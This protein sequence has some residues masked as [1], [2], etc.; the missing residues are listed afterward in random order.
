M[1]SMLQ[2]FKIRRYFSRF[3]PHTH[4]EHELRYV[5]VQGFPSAL[6]V[7]SYCQRRAIRLTLLVNCP[8]GSGSGTPNGTIPLQS[9]SVLFPGIMA[10]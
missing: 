10:K 7:S 9:T 4:M 1:I 5:N 8:E 3:R 2:H 6:H